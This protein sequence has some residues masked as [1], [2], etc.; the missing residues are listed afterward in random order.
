M[1]VDYLVIGGGS[2]GCVVA[3]RLSEDPSASVGL[4]EIG[5]RNDSVLV[6]WPAGYAKL[7]GEKFRWEWMTVP[8]KHLGD[9]LD[10]SRTA[11]ACDAEACCGLGEAGI[12]GP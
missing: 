9:R 3:S 12:V 8:Q 11:D 7:Q 2:A 6:N 4:L 10:D 5:A 1:E